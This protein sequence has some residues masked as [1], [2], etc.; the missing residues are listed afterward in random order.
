M[1]F[2]NLHRFRN[3]IMENFPAL[4]DAGGAVAEYIL[5]MTHYSLLLDDV[6][7]SHVRQQLTEIEFIIMFIIIFQDISSVAEC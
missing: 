7:D 1:N 3:I 5:G 2:I 4:K 6:P